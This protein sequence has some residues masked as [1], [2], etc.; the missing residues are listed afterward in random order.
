MI[1]IKRVILLAF[2][3]I[4]VFCSSGLS[5]IADGLDLPVPDL[6]E[7]LPEIAPLSDDDREYSDLYYLLDEYL[8]TQRETDPP[9]LANDADD[10]L[11]EDRDF[12][13]SDVDV[14]NDIYQLLYE[15]VPI[16]FSDD[17]YSEVP[18]IPDIGGMLPQGRSIGSQTR[19]PYSGGAF[20]ACNSNQG[21]GLLVLAE[22]YKSDTL[23][24]I[25]GGD[26]IVNLTNV[27]IS[28]Y[29]VS[30]GT[31][32]SLRIP[33]LG[34][35]QYYYSYGST[36]QWRTITISSVT[37]S[38]INFLDETGERGIENP[39]FSFFEKITLLVLLAL[40]FLSVFRFIRRV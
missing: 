1:Y 38:N 18:P 8:Q 31:T 16:G 11:S 25:K 4:F 17:I 22:P 34:E 29:W 27:Q 9:Y 12:V 3:C 2:V 20:V 39:R 13:Q 28:G 37:D 19:Y 40:L 36:N 5:V 14:L 21:Q 24:F 26:R 23:G 30:G 32:Y 10:D 35:P 6:S 15:R 7:P 33:S